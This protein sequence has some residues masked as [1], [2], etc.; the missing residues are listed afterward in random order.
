[1]CLLRLAQVD[2][3]RQVLQPFFVGLEVTTRFLFAAA[4]AAAVV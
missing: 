2:T 4:S 3:N 1:M